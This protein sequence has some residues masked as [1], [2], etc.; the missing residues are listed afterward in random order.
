MHKKTM[1][2][3]EFRD[4]LRAFMEALGLDEEPM[5]LFYT[6]KKPHRAVSPKAQVPVSRLP[7]ESD[8]SLNWLSC[9]LGTVRRARRNKAPACFD[10]AH[11]GCLGAAFYMG[12]KP[13]YEPF[14]PALISTG[15]PGEMEGECYLDSPEKGKSFYDGVMPPKAAG[16]HLVIQPLSLFEDGELPEIVILFPQR[17]AMIALNAL[18]VFLT[19]DSDAVRMPFGQGCCGMISWPRRYR[20]E[21][22]QLAVIGGFDI[23]G[24]RYLKK[25]EV[26]YAVPIELFTTMVSRWEEGMPGTRAWKR[27][28]GG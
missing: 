5:G 13:Y 9:A 19:G 16:S 21:G 24:L 22:C 26:S 1:N 18:T 8:G 12:F 27:V 11:Y 28:R 2:S 7:E 15:I 3:T 6:D 17:E 14:E 10:E 20:E 23:N 25:G 4:R